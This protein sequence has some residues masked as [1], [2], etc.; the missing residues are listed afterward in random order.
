MTP[1]P[2]PAL[3]D[4]LLSVAE[5]ADALHVAPVFVYRHAAELGGFKLGHLLRFSRIGIEGWLEA[6]KV[7]TEKPECQSPVE[8]ELVNRLIARDKKK[9]TVDGKRR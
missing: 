6:H 2:E 4:R 3:P 8:N 5:V 7:Q 1:D 9:R